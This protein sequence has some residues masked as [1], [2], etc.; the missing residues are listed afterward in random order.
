MVIDPPVVHWRDQ[1]AFA[2][3]THFVKK[4]AFAG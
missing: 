3:S 4:Y 2:M 1:R